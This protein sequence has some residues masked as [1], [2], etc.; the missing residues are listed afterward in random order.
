M[1]LSLPR[2]L[3]D[4]IYKFSFAEAVFSFTDAGCIFHISTGTPESRRRPQK[5]PQWLLT[6][7]QILGEGLSYFY[8]Q[9]T[10]TVWCE[11]PRTTILRTKPTKTKVLDKSMA[12]FSL[13][14]ASRIQLRV[15]LFASPPKPASGLLSDA[16]AI[17]FHP[18]CAY[19][20]Y[21]NSIVNCIST[22][23]TRLRY[24][25]LRIDLPYNLSTSPFCGSQTRITPTINLSNLGKL[26]PG[27]QR[28][29]FIV[30][31]P[32]V[33]TTTHDALIHAELLFLAVQRE[34]E[35]AA[36]AL[37]RHGGKTGGSILRDWLV[38]KQLGPFIS[39]AE[40]TGYEW[41][42]AVSYTEGPSTGSIQNHGM[43]TWED[44]SGKDTRFHSRTASSEGRIEWR[45]DTYG[46]IRVSI[47]D[48]T[49]PKV[50]IAVLGSVR[51]DESVL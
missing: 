46:T 4:E 20:R 18:S 24:I 36:K 9:A 8:E 2:E 26:G 34:L 48:K 28:V 44:I 49:M 13:S 27:V 51:K 22:Q 29:E 3:R 15:L 40:S 7:K 11:A 39:C 45:S 42:L 21:V 38:R 43:A 16:Y 14:R 32:Q 1:L 41:H 12:L 5:L 31:E 23:Q 10:C 33:D 50:P 37:V 35:S 19:T 25:K 30:S 6:S 47:L 17:Y